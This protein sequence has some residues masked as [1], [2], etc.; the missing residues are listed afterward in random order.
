MFDFDTNEGYFLHLVKCA[1]KSEQPT[2]APETVDFVKVL[3]ISKRH[4]VENLTFLSVEKLQRKIDD[5]LFASWQELYFKDQKRCLFQDMALEELVEAFTGKSIDCMPLKGSVIKNYYPNPDLRSMGDIDFLV[6]EQNRQ[7]VRDIMH[8]LGY[9]DD[10]LDDGQVDG[11]KKDRLVYVEIHY[12]F[13]AENHAYHDLFS[14]DW[15]KLLPTETQHLYKMD[16]EDL[17]FFNVGHYAKNMH[18]RGMGIR[19]VVDGYVLWNKM[20]VEQKHSLLNRFAQTELNDFHNRLLEIA[21]VWFDDKGADE[22]LML[23]Q[24]YL[25]NKP[26]YGNKKDEITMYAIR[27]NADASNL[28]YIIRK[29]FPSSDELYRRF[30]IKHRFSI[31]LPYLWIAR[32]FSQLFGNKAKW[33]KAKEQAEAFKTVKQDDIDYKRSVLKDFG[34]I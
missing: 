30:N 34:L 3:E 6:R 2:E 32:I 20:S 26:T 16:F 14:I 22:R 4:D 12:D 13:S 33:D 9:E 11:F 25:I 18:N 19:A 27:D 31:F 23:I 1:L 5:E 21:D 7:I 8:S 29:I 15:S 10:I 24:D 17:Y 28:K